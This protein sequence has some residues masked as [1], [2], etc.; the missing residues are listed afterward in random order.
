MTSY[1]TLVSSVLLV[2]SLGFVAVPALAARQDCGP[3]GA[4]GEFMEHHAKQM[5]QHHKK[6]HAALKLTADQ[7]TAWKK[8]MDS[9]QPMAKMPPAKPEDWA[10]LTTPERAD[11]MLERMQEHQAREVGHV[12]ALKEFYA[13]LTPEQKK[14]F[15]DF[16][17]GPHE[18]KHGKPKHHRASP[19]AKAPQ[20]P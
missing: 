6:L 18:R 19:P 20:S 8:L 14:A 10:K 16:H 15:D 12:A 13:V 2:S 1:R 3:G 17:S 7:E 9:E 4:R 5:E 11:K